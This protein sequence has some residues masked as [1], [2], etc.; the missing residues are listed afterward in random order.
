MK[1]LLSILISFSLSAQI[2]IDK[3]KES[4]D[5][6]LDYYRGTIICFGS[7]EVLT[8]YTHRPFLSGCIGFGIG[9]AQ[10]L[11]LERGA[12]GKVVSVMGS[13]LGTFCYI[14]RND[15]RQKKT[16]YLVDYYNPQI[17]HRKKKTN[18]W[19]LKRNGLVY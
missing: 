13:L 5:L 6:T 7:T 8:H 9:A 17:V 16:G 4:L 10:G 11:I 14:I 12:E 19:S 2:T 15:L 1:T 18:K 3:S